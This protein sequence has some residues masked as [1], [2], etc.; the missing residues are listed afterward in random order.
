MVEMFM[1]AVSLAIAAVPEGFLISSP[2]G[3]ARDGALSR[4]HPPALLG[5]NVGSATVICSD[6]HA[7]PKRHRRRIEVR[8]RDFEITGSGYVP[9][10]EFY[11]TAATGGFA[12][13][14]VL[15]L[16]YGLAPSTTR[17]LKAMWARTGRSFRVVGDPTEGS[18]LVAAAVPAL[19]SE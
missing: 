12:L 10:G 16:P 3:H 17:K 13:N 15:A 7:H 9:V 14:S 2:A 1:V 18:I 8:T 19:A 5:G 11:W 6:R 4:A